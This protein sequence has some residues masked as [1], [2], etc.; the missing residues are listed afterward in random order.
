[1]FSFR[2]PIPTKTKYRFQK[3]YKSQAITSSL[4][5]SGDVSP[6]LIGSTTAFIQSKN[7]DSHKTSAI[8]TTTSL[9]NLLCS[10]HISNAFCRHFL[11]F[12]ATSF[13]LS[14]FAIPTTTQK[15]SCSFSS[16]QNYPFELTFHQGPLSGQ[17]H[18]SSLASE[19]H[20]ASTCTLFQV[21]VIYIHCHYFVVLNSL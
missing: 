17:S 9:D 11:C 2:M 15:S 20:L 18:L 4:I 8:S 16:Q 21:A 10:L 5:Y 6:L 14:I 1:M 19:L 7:N 13:L 3:K 12:S